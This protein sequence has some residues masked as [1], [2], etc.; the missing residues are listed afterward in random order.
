VWLNLSIPSICSLLRDETSTIYFTAA[1]YLSGL[2]VC[3]PIRRS[4]SVCMNV[5]MW[6]DSTFDSRFFM[7]Q[8]LRALTSLSLLSS[9]KLAFPIVSW[10][11]FSLEIWRA[12]ANI[13]IKQSRIADKGWFFSVGFRRGAHICLP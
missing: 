8:N 7:L 5:A 3:F 11:L 2:V 1:F 9:C 6:E 13:L 4:Q 10:K 12:D